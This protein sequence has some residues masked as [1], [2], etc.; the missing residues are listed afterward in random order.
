M[1]CHVTFWSCD[2]IGTSV[3]LD[4]VNDIINGTIAFIRSSQLNKGQH[5]SFGHVMPL[6]LALALHNADDII[7][8]STAFIRSR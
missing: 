2:T 1:R 7:N 4:D 6:V 3:A 5:Y 8:G